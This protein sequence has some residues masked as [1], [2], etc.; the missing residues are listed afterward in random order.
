MGQRQYFFFAYDGSLAI[1][2]T[3]DIP[4]STREALR[5]LEEAGHFLT[6]NTGRLQCNALAYIE[7]AGFR[8]IVAAGGYSVTVYGQLL[9]IRG[10][11]IG[12]LKAF[13]PQLA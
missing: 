5:L 2:H 8:N 4:E 3:K 10:L 11:A 9:W 12:P 13:L 6:L 7:S 1:P